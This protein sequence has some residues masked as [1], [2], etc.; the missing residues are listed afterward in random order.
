[1][2]DAFEQT[3]AFAWIPTVL[4]FSVFHV[5]RNETLEVVDVL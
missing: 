3:Q 5:Y 1:M 4:C 2:P